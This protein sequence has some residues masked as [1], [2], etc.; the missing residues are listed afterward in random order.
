MKQTLIYLSFLLPTIL[1]SQTS[2]L[3]EG[4]H[5][6]ADNKG[7]KIHYVT[8]GEG[9]LVVMLHGFPDYWYTW[10][11]QMTMLKDDF[12]V[13][14]MDLRGY[15]LSGQPEGVE[16]YKMQHL[17]EDV[18]A[19][20]KANGKEKAIVVGHDWGGA[21]A[22]QLAI[23]RPDVVEKL[24]VCNMTHPTGRNQDLAELLEANGNNSY[25]DEFRKHTAETLPVAWLA[26]WVKDPVAKKHYETAFGRSYIDGMINYYK[27]NTSTKAQRAEW[28]KNP[29]N[30]ELPKVKMPVLAIFGLQ[31]KYVLKGGL[32]NTWNWL[33]MD[34]TLVTIPNA[35]HFVQQDA[36]EMVSKSMK[37]W[38][39]RDE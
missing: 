24:I 1:W 17:M 4:T 18:V 11:D 28:L 30:P 9:P 10:R 16:H 5:K 6:Y 33:E 23:H 36:P 27:A 29:V 35:G 31:D 32:N 7:V 20:I 38:L 21:I 15:N 26:G 37:M 12:Q 8:V 3:A 13:V 25:M 34:F 22:W 19:V 39:L 14:A 2:I